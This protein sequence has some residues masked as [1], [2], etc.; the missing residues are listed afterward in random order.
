MSLHWYCCAAHFS[1]LFPSTNFWHKFPA[2]SW[3]QDNSRLFY[4]NLLHRSVL[5]ESSWKAVLVPVFFFLQSCKH[6]LVQEL[7]CTYNLWI[8]YFDLVY[9]FYLSTSAS[10]DLLGI[11]VCLTM[12]SIASSLDQFMA[13]IPKW[14]KII[15]I[16]YKNKNDL[17]VSTTNLHALTRLPTA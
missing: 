6:K 11:A 4:E 8:K 12:Y 17:P 3:G 9:W 5:E 1:H 14:M 16:N 7:L 10:I 2:H 15:K 13:W